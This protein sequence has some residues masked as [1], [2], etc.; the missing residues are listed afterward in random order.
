MVSSN[1]IALQFMP[2]DR[3]K[4]RLLLSHVGKSSTSISRRNRKGESRHDRPVH[5][6]K[7]RTM[8]WRR[9]RHRGQTIRD[10]IGRLGSV[11]RVLRIRGRPA[12][13]LLAR[14][15]VV[16]GNV[17]NAVDLHLRRTVVLH[18]R[19]GRRGRRTHSTAGVRVRRMVES[20][21]ERF[22][23]ASIAAKTVE[24]S[25][26]DCQ[27]C[28]CSYHDSSDCTSRQFIVMVFFAAD[29]ERGCWHKG[30]RKTGD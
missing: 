13:V 21:F 25:S 24:E 17:G 11:V 22:D 3:R 20:A 19:R 1:A 9:H 28:D 12:S 15:W 2:R 18:G 29:R 27:S 30:A 16:R 14:A 8:I 5:M 23:L 4:E 26:N 6:R 10:R 7:R